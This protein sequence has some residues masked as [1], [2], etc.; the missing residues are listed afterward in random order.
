[1]VLIVPR[2]SYDTHSREDSE[3][4]ARVSIKICTG[5]YSYLLSLLILRAGDQMTEWHVELSSSIY[6]DLGVAVIFGLNYY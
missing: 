1:L 6:A 4:S 3:P 2:L 5:I